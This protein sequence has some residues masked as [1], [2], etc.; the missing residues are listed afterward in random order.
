MS[1]KQHRFKSQLNQGGLTRN[2]LC[3]KIS[4]NNML[5][6]LCPS[7]CLLELAQKTFKNLLNFDLL[8]SLDEIEIIRSFKNRIIQILMQKVATILQFKRLD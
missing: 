4:M 8:N 3:N 7:L 5:I 1:T 2:D 6:S